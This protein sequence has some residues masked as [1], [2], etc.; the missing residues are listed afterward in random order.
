MKRYFLKCVLSVFI[1]LVITGCSTVK[2]IKK[3]GN[4]NL[5]VLVIDQ[6]NQA[7]KDFLLV[8]KNDKNYGTALT[9]SQGVGRFTGIEKG[10]YFLSGKKHG[11]TVLTESPVSII[12]SGEVLCFQ[13]LNAQTVFDK[14]L[15]LFLE[16]KFNDGLY[17]LNDLCAAPDSVLLETL[18]LYKAYALN[19]QNQKG[20]AG[21]QLMLAAN[22]ENAQSKI[23]SP[24]NLY[25]NTA[26]TNII[27]ASE[28]SK[29]YELS[30]AFT[31]NTQFSGTF[32]NQIDKE[33]KAF[34]VVF[35]VLD[36]YGNSV[37]TQKANVVYEK[38]ETVLPFDICNFSFECSPFINQY[39]NSLNYKTEY[40][41]V[42]RI[43]YSDDSQWLDPFGIA[44]F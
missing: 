23:S 3:T 36:E 38:K 28:N 42:S 22:I 9:N 17:L 2:Q 10:D 43:V 1:I 12:P 25:Y 6:N 32:K 40:L 30:G 37:L 44:V 5:V 18:C 13:I 20:A 33:V 29:P 26:R 16:Q 4:S 35:N 31:K 21:L 24:L 27:Q 34:T 14:T 11:Y 15:S 41:Y 19:Q 39:E 8:L 7:V